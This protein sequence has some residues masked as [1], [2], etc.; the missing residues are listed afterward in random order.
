MIFLRIG[1]IECYGVIYKVLNKVNNKV[2]IGQTIKDRGFKG[3]YDYS[4]DG[5]ERIYKYISVRKGSKSYNSHLYK[6]IEKY[7]C[8]NFDVCE[9]FDIAFSKSELDLKEK[10]W[11][12]IY[13]STD[14]NYGYNFTDGGGSGKPT[15]DA[16]LKNSLSK[17]GKNLRSSNPNSKR[18]ICVTTGEVFECTLDAADKYNICRT[19]ISQ[20]CSGKKKSA[21][22]LNDGTKLVWMYYDE[23][24][25][26]PIEAKLRKSLDY[27]K[28]KSKCKKVTCITT[29]ITFSSLKDAAKYYNLKTSSN[30][31]SCCKGNLKYAGTLQDGTKLVWK[32]TE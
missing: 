19:A 4:G 26:F 20:S 14:R 15:K 13:K 16:N 32:Y 23:Y 2:Y 5:V 11:I 31:V 1:N 7:G 10:A 17:I 9:V 18:I 3:R 30:I 6:S 12:A 8:D 27:L 29:N 24:I 28:P 21:G 22:H 25:K